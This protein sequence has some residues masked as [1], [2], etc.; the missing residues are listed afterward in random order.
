MICGPEFFFFHCP[1]P[2]R[3]QAT[4]FWGGSFLCP[5]HY[6]HREERWLV[7]QTRPHP[8]DH[9]LWKMKGAGS[10]ERLPIPLSVREQ[11][12]VFRDGRLL[13]WCQR[14]VA[15]QV[16]DTRPPP[17]LPG[18]APYCCSRFSH[19]WA[20]RSIWSAI[21]T[22]EQCTPYLSQG[23]EISRLGAPGAQWGR[24]GRPESVGTDT[25]R[26]GGRDVKLA[27]NEG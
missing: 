4:V 10:P 19:C 22:A 7:T 23:R 1:S 27:R 20:G 25:P 6:T 8:L 11:L 14:E 26:S 17:F 9:F 18:P 13:L 15:P 2:V 21:K 24:R 5:T 16:T 12:P 3:T